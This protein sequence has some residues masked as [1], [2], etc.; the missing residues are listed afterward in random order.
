[1]LGW[2]LRCDVLLSRRGAQIPHHIEEALSRD[3]ILASKTGN[4]LVPNSLL[5]LLPRT[6][7]SLHNLQQWCLLQRPYTLSANMD[8]VSG[9]KIFARSKFALSFAIYTYD[10]LFTMMTTLLPLRTANW[11][12]M[13][14]QTNSSSTVWSYSNLFSLSQYVLELSLIFQ[15]IRKAV[16]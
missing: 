2:E 1:M 7:I 12:T 4:S 5:L 3:H 10:Y 14:I 11:Q 8:R 9:L 6:L 16:E 15:Q 13:L